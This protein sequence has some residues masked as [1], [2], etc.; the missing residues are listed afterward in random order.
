[1]VAGLVVDDLGDKVCF[2]QVVFIHN[3]T[4]WLMCIFKILRVMHHVVFQ[5]F[6]KRLLD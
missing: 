1:M 6:N 2:C 5:F 4:P 3:F